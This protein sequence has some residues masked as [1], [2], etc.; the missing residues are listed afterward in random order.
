MSGTDLDFFMYR[1]RGDVKQKLGDLQ[2]ALADL[3]SAHELEPNNYFTLRYSLQ[4]TLCRDD[5]SQVNVSGEFMTQMGITYLELGLGF[6]SLYI[7]EL[8]T[9]SCLIKLLWRN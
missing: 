3:N 6:Q 2:G 7:I 4:T 8:Y 1:V 9:I 5:V